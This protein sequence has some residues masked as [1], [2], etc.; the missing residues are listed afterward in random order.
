[1]Q[2]DGAKLK[3]MNGAKLKHNDTNKKNVTYFNLMTTR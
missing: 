3:T 2:K 1:M